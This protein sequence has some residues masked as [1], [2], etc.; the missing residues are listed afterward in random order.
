M[1]E[2]VP[3]LRRLLAGEEVTTDGR[4]VHLE[5][6]RLDWPPQQPVPVLAAGE[7]PKTLALTGAVADGT[8]VSRG[9]RRRR[10]CAARSSGSAR[11][12]PRRVARAGTRWSCS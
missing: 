6:V 9:L 3:A 8:V 1:R 11:A 10:I 7:G 2:Y 5:R 12:A 4:Y